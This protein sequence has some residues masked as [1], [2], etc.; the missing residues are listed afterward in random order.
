MSERARDDRAA[1]GTGGAAHRGNIAKVQLYQALTNFSLFMPV[2]IV[3]L[4]TERGLTLT[5]I[6]VMMGLSWVLMAL[7]EVP[8]GVLADAV[9]RRFTLLVGTATVAAGIAMMALVPSYWGVMAGYLAW[10]VG[11]ALQSGSDMALQYDSLRADGREDAYP[12]VAGRSYALIQLAQGVASVVGGW[13]AALSLGLPLLLTSVLTL[14]GLGAVLALKEPPRGASERRP[15]LETLRSAVALVRE[16]PDL[17]YL[18]FYSALV[19]ACAWNVVFLLFQPFA[20]DHHIAVAWIGALFLVLRLAG[21]AGSQTGPYMARGRPLGWSLLGGP[22]L[23]CAALVAIAFSGSWILG[24]GCML[25]I[26]FIQGALRPVLSDRLNQRAPTA[27]RATL[28]SLQSL[29]RTLAT[30]LLQPLLGWSS[31]QWGLGTAF[32]LL[33]GVVAVAV[34][35]RLLWRRVAPASASAG[36]AGSGEAGG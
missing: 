30:A 1:R 24:F 34:P 7:A 36:A 19:S 18:I 10:S 15:Y 21:V 33:A 26:G 17:R 6:T 22:L 25:L 32:L 31:D 8:T 2:W 12:A 29:V 23:F 16:Q 28:L 4:Q 20:M 11:M 9:G 13:A 14:L 3:F 35:L 5:Q 27:T